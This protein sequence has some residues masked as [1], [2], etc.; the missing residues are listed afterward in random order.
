MPES[1]Q[2]KIGGEYGEIRASI[3]VEKLNAYLLKSTAAIRTPVDV[4]QFKSNPTYF[5]TDA[6]QKKFV[7]RKKPAGKLLSQTAHQIE[8]EYTMLRALHKHN[9][10]PST[11]PA[12]Y[13]PVPEP[14][15]LCEDSDIIGTPFYVMEYLDGR[16]FT[17]TR[18]LEV[19]P[20][21]RRECW[22]SVIHTLAALG[23]IT[24]AAV[25]LENFG[26]ST[27]Y[28]P[29]QIK[30]YPE[31]PAP[32][33]R[34]ENRVIGILDWELCTLGS[35]LADLANLTQPWSIDMNDI[36]SGSYSMRGFKGAPQDAPVPL[37]DLEREYCSL[38]K[39]AY[40]IKEMTFVRSWMLFRLS[41][42]SQGIAARYARRQASSEH[43]YLHTYGFPVIGNLARRVLE[44]QGITIRPKSKL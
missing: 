30:S 3:D 8:R 17:D 23:S 26:P 38:T 21:D 18:M 34:R 11:S 43:A 12:Q 15:L 19:S 5:L 22:L 25:G 33:P 28:F 40:P 39:Q 7:L 1:P 10:Q 32:R 9:T 16:I 6:S 27:D 29:R 31:Y 24:P 36:P 35:P 20:K 14:I 37:E 13:V 42:I 2:K 4:K 44:E 41:V